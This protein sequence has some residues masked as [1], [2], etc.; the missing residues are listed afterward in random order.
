MLLILSNAALWAIVGL[1]ACVLVS[2][3]RSGW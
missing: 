2:A 3:A 1:G